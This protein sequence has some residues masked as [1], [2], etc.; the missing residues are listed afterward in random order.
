MPEVFYRTA[1]LS[2]APVSVTARGGAL[3]VP[4]E[5]QGEGRH[6]L[7]ADGVLYCSAEPLSAVCECLKRFRNLTVNNQVFF[8]PAGLKMVLVKFSL[9]DANLVD[10][11]QAKTLVK[12]NLAPADIATLDRNITQK[13]A[14]TIYAGGTDGFWWWSTLEARWSN[15]T[16]FSARV[17]KRLS[18]VEEVVPLTIKTEMVVQAAQ[19]LSLTLR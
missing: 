13:V 18:V 7:A 12:L 17:A 10:L 6:D 8:R 19:V 3:Y 14:Q 9:A 15:A 1:L 11:R 5:Y 4:R 16:L 2:D